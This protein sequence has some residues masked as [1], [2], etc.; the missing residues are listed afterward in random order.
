MKFK[1]SLKTLMR[2]RKI[3]EELAKGEYYNAK[4]DVDACLDKIEQLYASIDK[5]R[6]RSAS[7]QREGNSK[8]HEL[9]GL[10]T[11]I[12]GQLIRIEREKESME[13]MPRKG[14]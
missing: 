11:F 14:F 12:R 7:M 4:S 9:A 8:G 10:D 1:F 5:T 6:E 2:H 3:L 13:Q